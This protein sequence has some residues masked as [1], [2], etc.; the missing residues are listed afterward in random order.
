DSTFDQTIAAI[1]CRIVNRLDDDHLHPANILVHSTATR[2]NVKNNLPDN[3]L[4][5]PAK[6]LNMSYLITPLRR[7]CSVS[8]FQR[9]L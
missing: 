8:F 9:S 1:L 2:A 3:F 7:N 6:V 5:Y 4:Y